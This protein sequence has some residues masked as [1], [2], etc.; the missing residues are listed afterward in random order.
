M[1]YYHVGAGWVWKQDDW[2]VF[3]TGS[4]G[5]AELD[6]DSLMLTSENEFSTSVGGGIKVWAHRNIGFRFELRGYWA[7]FET[8]DTDWWDEFGDAFVQGE[9]RVGV[10]VRF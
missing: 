5:V 4:I 7:N 8:G 10:V 6:P 9:A 1:T 2:E 3:V